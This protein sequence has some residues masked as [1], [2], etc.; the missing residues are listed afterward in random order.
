MGPLAPWAKQVMPNHS[1]LQRWFLFCLVV[2]I[3]LHVGVLMIPI[4]VRMGEPASATQPRGPLAVTLHRPPSHQEMPKDD[5][6]SNQAVPS[7]PPV[8][9]TH[10]P[11]SPTKPAFTVAPPPVVEPPNSPPVVSE[12]PSDM[13]AMLEAKRNKR[14]NEE[15]QAALENAEAAA[16]SNGPSVD[17]RIASNINRNLRKSKSDG[18]GGMFQITH[19]GVREG[20]FRF[21]GWHPGSDNWHE[22]YTV[23]AGIGGNV[24]LAIVKKV[25]EVIR[26]YKTGDF[27]F[28]SRKLGRSVT[29]SARPEDND[30]LVE[31]L[32]K[33]F[34]DESAPT[35][36]G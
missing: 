13:S 27:E 5:I 32:M 20:E 29:M 31:F 22:S 28:D 12:Q 21:N 19:V 14:Q 33:E 26:K 25:I 18:T 1:R 4:K 11:K 17:E 30:A 36:K 15:A 16:G 3:L 10:R 8:I 2:S 35:G 24:R 6:N 7:R 34:F 9:A 23:D